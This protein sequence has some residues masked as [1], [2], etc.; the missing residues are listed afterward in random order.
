[1]DQNLLSC[2]DPGRRRQVLAAGWN[3][4][5][6]VEIEDDTESPT[7]CV[8]FFGRIPQS[9]V[10]ASLRIEGGRRVRDITVTAVEVKRS[11]DPELDDCLRVTVDRRGDLSPYRLCLVDAEGAPALE[12]IDPRYRCAEFFFRIDCLACSAPAPCPPEPPPPAP[13]INY[14][15]KDY[16]SFRQLVLDRLAAIAPE[17]QERHAADLGQTLLE[18]LAYVGDSLSYFQDAVATEAYLESARQRISVRRHARLVDYA[19]HEGCN[20]RAFVVLT[21]DSDLSLPVDDLFFTTAFAESG[22]GTNPRVLS[23]DDLRGAPSGS[24]EVFEPVPLPGQTTVKVTAAHSEIDLWTWGDSECCL[25]RGATRATL[26]DGREP[27]LTLAPGDLLAFEERAS[28]ETGDPADADPVHRHVVRLT[29]TTRDLDP[30][31]DQPVLEVEWDPSDALPFP[32]C[33]SADSCPPECRPLARLAVARGNVIL[34]DHGATGSPDEPLG[35]VPI[36]AS[37][38]ECRCEGALVEVSEQPGRFEPTL[39]RWPLTFRGAAPTR[40]TPAGRSLAQDPRQALPAA[41]LTETPAEAGQP[42]VLWEP[43]AHL[44]DSGPDDDHFL[45]ETDNEG[46][47]HLR[48]GDDELGRQ[49]PARAGFDAH[50]RVGN[51]PAGNVGPD[52]ITE[53]VLRETSLTGVLLRVRN[54]LAAVGGTA[55]EPID[56]VKQLAPGAFREILRR[57]VTASDYAALA[58][59]PDGVPST[60]IQQAAARLA[61]SGSWYEAEV[62]LDPFGTETASPHLLSAV[63]A[64]LVPFRRIGH[65]LR[66][67]AARYV[68][69]DLELS[70]CV[71]PQHLQREV[72]AAVLDLLGSGLRAD[73]RPGFFHPDNFTFGQGVFLSRIVGAV[74]AVPGVRSVLVSKMRRLFE[75]PL[76]DEIANGVLPIGFQEIARLDNDPNLPENGRLSIG[77]EGGR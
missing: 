47:A 14:L 64:A 26:R 37:L 76:G 31:F 62:A 49:P 54:P 42:R 30:V 40:D 9:L 68:P 6:Y 24:F 75:P 33:I 74:Q 17:W 13:E 60:V 61:W 73:G 32:L 4:I 39:G 1:M 56:D 10:P 7:L 16:G 22:C 38:G 50:Y 23:P 69:L 58:Q 34:V 63:E 57:A 46:R 72:V 35:Q 3:G 20:A 55:A 21:S 27:P 65:D 53:I 45:V 15:A 51:G 8:H 43:R 77:A 2:Q 25:P 29:R 66:V 19:M 71:Q 70:L 18:L 5:D 52:T 48:F 28:P 41:T 12:R 11:S 44:L 36:A 67:V 59:A